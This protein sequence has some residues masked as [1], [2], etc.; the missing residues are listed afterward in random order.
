MK[1]TSHR[2]ISLPM[3]RNLIISLIGL[4]AICLN[5][6]ENWQ[7]WNGVARVNIATFNGVAIANV[8]S[9]NGVD[10]T[11]ASFDPGSVFM[12]YWKPSAADY[13]TNAG[14]TTLTDLNSGAYPLTNTTAAGLPTRIAAGIDSQ[15]YLSFDG[16]SDYLRTVLLTN[17]QPWQLWTVLAYLG[18]TGAEA[19]FDGTTASSSIW[20]NGNLRVSAGANL[21]AASGSTATITNRWLLYQFTLNSTSSSAKTNGVNISSGNAGSNARDGFIIGALA[22]LNFNGPIQV[23]FVGV[24]SSNLPTGSISNAL[25]NYFDTNWPTLGLP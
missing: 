12:A 8:A 21:D 18:G 5:A 1:F 9:W 15:D 22:G 16:A 10:N 4:S 23:A 3:F 7:S 20:I 17:A 11:S 24:I 6:A 14:L 13:T 25:W 2:A 19:W